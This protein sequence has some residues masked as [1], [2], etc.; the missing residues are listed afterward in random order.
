MTEADHFAKWDAAEAEQ[1]AVIA[2]F[3]AFD[4]VVVRR[5][6]L[7]TGEALDRPETARTVRPGAGRAVTDGPF[8]ETAEQSAGSTWSTCPTTDGGRGGALLPEYT[9]EIRPTIEIELTPLEPR[10]RGVGPAAGPARR[11]VPPARPRR[12]RAGRGVRGGRPDPGRRTGQ[13]GGVAAD[14][15]PAPDPRPA[16]R[17]GD[18]GATDALAGDRVSVEEEAQ[19][20]GRRRRARARR[21]AAAGAALRPPG[22]G[23]GV[24]GRA[25]A[26]ARPGRADRRHRPAVPGGDT[27]DGRPADPRPQAAGRRSRS[28]SPTTSAP[29]SRSSPTWPTWPSPPAT[30]RAAGPTCCGPSWP[31]RRSGW[32]GCSARS[33]PSTTRGRLAARPDAAPALPA[34][35]PRRTTGG[36]CCCPTRTGPAGTRRDRRGG[37]AA[38]P[39][40][41]A[42]A[43]PYLL[44]ALIAAEH[45]IAPTAGGHR[46]G[47]DRA[48]YAEL[49]ALTGSRRPAQPGRRR[50]GGHGPHAGL[51]VLTG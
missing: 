20:A 51:A 50:R 36:W 17:R 25:D 44:Q 8:A 26:A 4:E 37:P 14:R 10:A 7:L 35:R 33:S 6:A 5:G 34:R 9:V 11:A 18:G 29:G 46:L 45:A 38:A 42:P 41:G 12:G 1:Q 39:V 19:R 43:S 21:A 32:S 47:P 49:E 31:A 48:A 28:R 16:A 13:P 15:G 2:C 30:R 40:G 27:D 22:P 23:A 3:H 24:G